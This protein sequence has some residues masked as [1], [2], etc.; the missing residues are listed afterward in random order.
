[1]GSLHK[2]NGQPSACGGRT[3]IVFGCGRG[4]TSAMAGALRTIGIPF[5]SNSHPLKH[6]SSPI[7]YHGDQVDRRAT[8][9]N[10]RAMDERFSLWGWK[11]PRDLFSVHSW[12]SMVRDPIFVLIWRDQIQTTLSVV[13]REQMEFEVALRH[14]GEAYA[15]LGRFAFTVP[16]PVAIVDYDELCATPT[17]LLAELAEWVGCPLPEERLAQATR[18][19]RVGRGQYAAINDINTIVSP[20]EIAIDQV[21]TQS[22]LYRQALADLATATRTL[23]K[24]IY[25]AQGMLSNLHHRLGEHYDGLGS[26]SPISCIAPS[27]EAS[28]VTHYQFARALFVERSTFRTTLQR[29]MDALVSRVEDAGAEK[30]TR[31]LVPG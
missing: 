12:V 16:F 8:E 7:V 20:E 3:V 18:F 10:L 19:L 1:M 27:I 6:E 2:L 31:C 4:G 14:V 28:L 17:D 26:T 23:D 5:P 25:A 15:E 22:A 29:R 30:S 21:A 11:S 9:T 13:T 24:D